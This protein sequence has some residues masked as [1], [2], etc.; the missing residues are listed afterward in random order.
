[1]ATE[2]QIKASNKYNKTNTVSKHL[3]LNL[4]TDSDIIEWLENK[5]YATY[6]KELIRKDM[7]DKNDKQRNSSQ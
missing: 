5:S 4:K 6:I 2:A 1:M 7:K 3:R